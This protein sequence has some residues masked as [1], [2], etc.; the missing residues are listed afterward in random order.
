MPSIPTSAIALDVDDDRRRPYATPAM[1][2]GMGKGVA[3][4]VLDSGMIGHPG[5]TGC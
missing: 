5:S 2:V 3:I 1:E 4:K